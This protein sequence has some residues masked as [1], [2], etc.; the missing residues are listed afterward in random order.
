MSGAGG[1]STLRSAGGLSE[2]TQIQNWATSITKM[3]RVYIQQN[4]IAHYRKAMF[5]LLSSNRKIEFT[6]IA[7]SKS[8]TPFMKV[9]SWGDSRIRHRYARTQILKL[10]LISGLFWQPG[11]IAIVAREKPDLVIALGN[12]YSLT[13]WTLLL[14]G[15]IRRIPICLWGHGLLELESGPKWFLR[16]MFYRLASAQLLYGDFSKKLLIKSGFASNKLHVVYNS[17]DYDQQRRIAGRISVRDIALFRNSLGLEEDKRL[18]VFTGRLQP[19]K[20]LDLLFQAIANIAERGQDVHIALIGEGSERYS[21]QQLAQNL[22][23]KHLV[24]FL[25]AHYDEEFLGLTLSASDLCIVPSGAGLSII[26]SMVFGT[27]VIIHD[28]VAQHGPEWEAVQEG[29]TGF[30]YKYEDIHDL[31]LKIEQ[32]LFPIS[33]KEQMS[34][35]CQSIIRIKYNPNRQVEIIGNMVAQVINQ[36]NGW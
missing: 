9:V 16:K 18:V 1:M 27:P 2:E 8:D 12:P 3:T 4:C 35:A 22:K 26:H 36:S 20:R 10:P 24:H 13:T 32:A 6:F 17:L 25:G 19:V 14:L 34:D 5:E 7:D 23:I 21:L 29:I 11:A 31:T 33:C 30:F 28:R 15:R